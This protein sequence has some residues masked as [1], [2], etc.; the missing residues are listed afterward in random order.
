MYEIFTYILAHDAYRYAQ[1]RHQ[2]RFWAHGGNIV[3]DTSCLVPLRKGNTRQYGRSGQ[4][5]NPSTSCTLA[6]VQAWPWL[7][8]KRSVLRSV[9]RSSVP[10]C[11]GQFSL[12]AASLTRSIRAAASVT[13]SSSGASAGGS[14]SGS[15]G[16][17]GS[18]SGAAGGSGSAGT[19]SE[20]VREGWSQRERGR[21]RVSMLRDC[22]NGRG[23]ES[24]HLCRD[25]RVSGGI[26]G[27]MGRCRSDPGACNTSKYCMYVQYSHMVWYCTY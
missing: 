7:T 10:E 4:E 23:A 5:S 14:G 20:A 3:R 26:S 16:A 9:L 21:L 15:G 25:L 27:W 13:A 6:S 8:P 18:G 17:G 1:R 11:S 22:Q 12:M 24:R 2:D 19:G